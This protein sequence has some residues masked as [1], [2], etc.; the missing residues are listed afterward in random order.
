[1]RVVLGKLTSRG[2][3]AAIAPGRL[4]H[5][6]DEKTNRRFLCD[7]GASYSV[8]PFRSSEPPSG[9]SLTG[10]NGQRILCWGEKELT[11]SFNG[12]AY[13]WIFLLADV[14]FPILGIDFLRHYHLVV[15]AASGQLV[16]TR[17]MRVFPAVS[18]DSQRR[19]G[20]GVFSCIGE[21][22]PLFR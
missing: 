10:P 9:P 19:G 1:M 15:D 3:L 14:S 11:L 18:T 21:T 22:P 8:F 6:L 12:A 5:V 16:D 2:R 13:T 7:T 17:T 4:V 20:K